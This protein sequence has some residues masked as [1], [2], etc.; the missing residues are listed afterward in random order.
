MK[1]MARHVV[2]GI[3]FAVRSGMVLLCIALWLAFVA[4]GG[5]S[6]YIWVTE[7]GV[8]PMLVTMGIIG[9]GFALLVALAVGAMWFLEWAE[10]Y[11]C[12]I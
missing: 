11:N 10:N 3:A 1:R 4:L 7:Y 12:R 5:I 2:C 8:I 6:I 9:A